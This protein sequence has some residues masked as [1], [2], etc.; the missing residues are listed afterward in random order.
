MPQSQNFSLDQRTVQRL[1]QQQLRFVKLLELSAPELEQAVETELA[2]NPAL[3]K[4]SDSTSAEN[5]NLT[6]DG[7]KFNESAEQM[8]KADYRDPDD[9]PFYR[10][11]T[12]SMAKEPDFRDFSPADDAESIYDV[13]S[14]QLAVRKLA[15]EVLNVAEYIVG[16]IDPNGYLRRSKADII[17]DMAFSE[18]IDVADETYDAALREVRSLEPHGIGATDLRDCL[19]LQVKALPDSPQRDDALTILEKYF[20]EFAMKH[21]ARIVSQMKV[22]SERVRDAI[23]LIQSLNPKPGASLGTGARESA[24]G[25][26]PDFIINVDGSD[27]SVAIPG[28]PEIAIEE[29]F[30]NA[31][32]RMKQNA[33]TRAARKGNEFILSRFNAAKDFIQ[34]VRKRRETLFAVMT[35]IVKIQQQY[36]LTQDVRKLRPMMIKDIA[37]LTG[38]DISVISRATANKY[39]ATPWGIFPLR[40]FFS[41]SLG[42]EGEEFTN[43]E[44]EAE[45]KEIVDSEDKKHP[46]SDE[47]IRETLAAK[48]FDVSRRTVAKYRDRL[49]IPVARLRKDS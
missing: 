15:P 28:P 5:N 32:S 43:R 33:A 29:S 35:A 13:L 36:F 27:I 39:A 2:E 4:K 44:V 26:I 3:E 11:E 12:R 24:A 40:F 7:S 34:I 25:I 49:R 42:E 9:I 20:S 8:Q 30:A 1:T 19:E 41:D 46:L 18:G 47:K 10:L 6:D 23:E 14:R 17:D 45:I 48:G 31:V 16:S 38:Y 21:T 37:E 22:D